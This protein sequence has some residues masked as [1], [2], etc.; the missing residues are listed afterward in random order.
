MAVR[1]NIRP[2]DELGWRVP[3]PGT[4]A[5]K[6]YALARKG[7]NAAEI[8]GQ[9]GRERQTVAA[10]LF[11]IKQPERGNQLGNAWRERRPNAPRERKP[12]TAEEAHARKVAGVLG[13][14]REQA[15]AMVR[16]GSPE[17]QY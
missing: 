2:R 9:L 6:I 7:L 4:V 12:I 13:V 14:S 5:A 17:Q 10:H 8:A 11:K 3:R 1:P 16:Q 15:R